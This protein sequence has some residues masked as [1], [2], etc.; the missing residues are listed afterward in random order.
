MKSLEENKDFEH[1]DSLGIRRK[2]L[3][4]VMMT[5]VAV[6][7]TGT[8]AS[9]Q[10]SL[11]QVND[12]PDIMNEDLDSEIGDNEDLGGDSDIDRDSDDSSL[13][14]SQLGSLEDGPDVK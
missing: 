9:F 14:V 7:L 1:I 12:V 3:L 5:G 13:I 2:V 10:S 8:Q 11:D 4:C 6:V